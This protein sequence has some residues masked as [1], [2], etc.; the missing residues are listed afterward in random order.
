VPS[1]SNFNYYINMK[2]P[3]SIDPL[4]K[5]A[6]AKIKR[7]MKIARGWLLDPHLDF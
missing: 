7:L 2:N 3:D 1:A 5:K 4:V 6:N